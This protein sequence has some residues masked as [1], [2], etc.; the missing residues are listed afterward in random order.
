MLG[1]LL[2]VN[3]KTIIKT[4]MIWDNPITKSKV[5]QME[6]LFRPNI[7]TIKVK[8]QDDAHTS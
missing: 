3:L 2:V 5:K 6:H 7:P 1:Y 8:L 4:N